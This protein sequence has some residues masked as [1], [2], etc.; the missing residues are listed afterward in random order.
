M[1]MVKV[2]PFSLNIKLFTIN[3][4]FVLNSSVDESLM[5]LCQAYAA[6][7]FTYALFWVRFFCL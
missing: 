1:T 7:I 4:S 6:A 3:K 5:M 2:P